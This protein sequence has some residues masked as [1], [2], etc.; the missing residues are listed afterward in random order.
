MLTRSFIEF[1][2][3]GID[4]FPM[5]LLMYLENMSYSFTNY[6][7]TILCNSKLKST[8]INHNLQYVAFNM[9]FLKKKLY[10]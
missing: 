5:T 10:V 6:F 3:L 4:N 9:S 7:P 8:V 1:C 2:V